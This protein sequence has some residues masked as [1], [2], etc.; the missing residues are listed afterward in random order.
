M[1][2]RGGEMKGREVLF[3]IDSVIPKERWIEMP[4]DI[5]EWRHFGSRGLYALYTEGGLAYIGVSHDLKSRIRQH[6][7]RSDIKITKIKIVG[8]VAMVTA[9]NIPE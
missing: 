5:K 3:E 4:T 2:R 9:A 8:I 7:R 6:L 1:I